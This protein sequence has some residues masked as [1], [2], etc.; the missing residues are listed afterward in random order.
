MKETQPTKSKILCMI[1]EVA[2]TVVL[3]DNFGSIG[4]SGLG[5]SSSFTYF[6][7]VVQ[8]QFKALNVRLDDLQS[9]P[10]YRSPTSRNNDEEE[11]EEYLDGRNNE[12]ERRRKGEPRHDNY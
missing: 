2:V 5:S 7:T 9:T 8:E 6:K 11:E 4:R 12:N 1:L 10:R 3:I